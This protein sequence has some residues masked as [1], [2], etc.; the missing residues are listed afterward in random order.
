MKAQERLSRKDCAASQCHHLKE[1]YGVVVQE[2]WGRTPHHK[3]VLWR[4]LKCDSVFKANAQAFKRMSGFSTVKC[5]QLCKP[6][7]PVNHLWRTDLQRVKK[8]ATHRQI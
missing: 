2:S 5:M 3:K 7:F 1:H 8:W 6:I 4:K